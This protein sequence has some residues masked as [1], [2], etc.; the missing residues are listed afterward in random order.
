MIR[1][2]CLRRREIAWNNPSA[3]RLKQFFVVIKNF[4]GESK[5]ETFTLIAS[6]KKSHLIGETIN[7]SSKAISKPQT[8]VGTE[9]VDNQGVFN[10]IIFHCWIWFG[11]LSEK[12]QIMFFDKLDR[13]VKHGTLKNQ[14]KHLSVSSVIFGHPKLRL[15]FISIVHSHLA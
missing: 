3:G 6:E 13:R 5:R 14:V 4:G 2:V 7:K 10:R 12:N 9:F 15:R 1:T 11:Y 8:D